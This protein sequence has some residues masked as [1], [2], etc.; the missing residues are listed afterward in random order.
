M[1]SLL[2]RVANPTVSSPPPAKS[3]RISNNNNDIDMELSL[4]KDMSSSVSRG[5]D[6]NRTAK[7]FKNRLKLNCVKTNIP[8]GFT[9]VKAG[10]S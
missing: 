6:F 3:R 1:E 5:S 2:S 10:N 4:S 7:T 8:K 9:E